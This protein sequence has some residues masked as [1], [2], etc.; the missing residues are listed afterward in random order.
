MKRLLIL[1]ALLLPFGAI[2]DNHRSWEPGTYWTVTS[3][4]TKPG[5][6]DA[7]ISDLKNNWRRAMEAQKANGKVKTYMMFSN[8]NARADEGD[9]YLLVE[10]NSAAD[11]LDTPPDY[12][13]GVVADVFGSLD[14]ADKAN[15]DRGELRTIMSTSLLRSLSFAD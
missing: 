3:V 12:F 11:M 13:E 5:K 7:Y 1:A 10:W 8:V 2:A 14:D 9:L 6:F 15:I 4:D